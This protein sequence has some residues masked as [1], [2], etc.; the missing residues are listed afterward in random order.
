MS[1]V[2]IGKNCIKCKKP[3]RKVRNSEYKRNFPNADY[4]YSIFY[5]AKCKLREHLVTEMVLKK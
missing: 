4:T 1:K 5:C 3:L 2:K